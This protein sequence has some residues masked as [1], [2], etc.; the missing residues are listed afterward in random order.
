MMAPMTIRTRPLTVTMRGPTAV[1]T[2]VQGQ[3]QGRAHGIPRFGRQEPR[4]GETQNIWWTDPLTREAIG[5]ETQN[6][7]Q[8]SF[9]K[10]TGSQSEL[11]ICYANLIIDITGNIQKFPSTLQCINSHQ[12]FYLLEN[13]ENHA[14]QPDWPYVPCSW[15]FK[16]MWNLHHRI[17]HSIISRRGPP[18][19]FWQY[20]GLFS[21]FGQC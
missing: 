15:V 21:N 4:G 19:M 2:V 13:Q 14:V 17:E 18:R 6:I 11:I 9:D 8:V 3:A 10:V 16:T 12:S 1:Q 7:W 20:L 5:R